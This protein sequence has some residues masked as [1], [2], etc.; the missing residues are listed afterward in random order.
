M[1]TF[2]KH[3]KT[4]L[5]CS[6]LL[7]FTI[8]QSF[9]DQ[10]PVNLWRVP[11]AVVK[12]GSFH[13]VIVDRGELKK[14]IASSNGNYLF[15]EVGAGVQS[16]VLIGTSTQLV[17]YLLNNKHRLIENRIDELPEIHIG[18]SPYIPQDRFAGLFPIGDSITEVVTQLTNFIPGGGAWRD[19]ASIPGTLWGLKAGIDKLSESQKQAGTLLYVKLSYLP[20]DKM[21]LLGR[22]TIS[23]DQI[24]N[25]LQAQYL[26]ESH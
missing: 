17:E 20:E 16:L 18:I 5:T 23:F 6:A 3:L 25:A 19:I 26:K 22:N 12:E 1:N 15:S 13:S 9:A 4:A 2:S 11:S 8:T 21:T 10:I 14:A 24:L 7:F